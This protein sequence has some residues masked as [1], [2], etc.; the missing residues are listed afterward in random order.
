MRSDNNYLH[1]I[2]ASF[3]LGKMIITIPFVAQH[4]IGSQTLK[5]AGYLRELTLGLVKTTWLQFGQPAF[6]FISKEY[7][8]CPLALI[9]SGAHLEKIHF[10]KKHKP[11]GEYGTSQ[12]GWSMA[13]YWWDTCHT[14]WPEKK[15]LVYCVLRPDEKATTCFPL[16]WEALVCSCVLYINH[17]GKKSPNDR[18]CSFEYKI[19]LGLCN[20]VFLI[21]LSVQGTCG[22]SVTGWIYVLR[23]L[24]MI[25]HL[26]VMDNG[27]FL[28][29]WIINVTILTATHL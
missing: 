14:C 9:P 29:I 2:V 21:V 15:A 20:T 17:G 24:N 18:L 22:S 26:Y 12:G 23:K 4:I 16:D 13:M 28:S 25:R 7:A 27:L 10:F 6:L 5:W 11:E 1:W 8:H 3:P 19:T